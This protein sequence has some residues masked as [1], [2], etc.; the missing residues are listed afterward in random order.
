[1]DVIVYRWT[2]ER[3]TWLERSELEAVRAFL[4]TVGVATREL[5]DGSFAFEDGSSRTVSGAR[6]FVLAVRH[7]VRGPLGSPVETPDAVAFPLGRVRG[8]GSS[9]GGAMSIAGR[10]VRL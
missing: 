1:V 6:L 9:P 10:Q 2:A 8:R 7:L 3:D 4:A 5:P